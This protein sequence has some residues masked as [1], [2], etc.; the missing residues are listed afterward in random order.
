[1]IKKSLFILT[2][3]LWA[4]SLNANSFRDS[5]SAKIAPIADTYLLKTIGFAPSSQMAQEPS[6]WKTLV[7]LFSSEDE[8]AK[9]QAIANYIYNMYIIEAAAGFKNAPTIRLDTAYIGAL[10]PIYRSA[11]RNA[12]EIQDFYIDNLKEINNFLY[13]AFAQKMGLRYNPSDKENNRWQSLYI[14]ALVYTYNTTKSFA[15]LPGK[16]GLSS[17]ELSRIRMDQ[18]K[19]QIKANNYKNHNLSVL[20][21][22]IDP[23]Q[24]ID[25]YSRVGGKG[26]AKKYTYRPLSEEC[27]A[28]T[29]SFC[30]DICAATQNKYGTHKLFRV[31]EIYAY[32]E[33]NFLKNVQGKERFNKPGGGTYPEWYYHAAALLVFEDS[34]SLSFTVV[35]TLLSAEPISFEAWIN[36]FYKPTT[37]FTIKPFI[38]NKNTEKNI[39][40][41]KDI[42]S[43][44][45]PHQVRK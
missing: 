27:A 16:G 3:F 39:K 34:G 17:K 10:D 13:S 33:S 22:E 20:Y 7:S 36:M 14:Q 44:Y 30:K 41:N 1:M 38:R 19:R 6:I 42:P 8:E 40:N 9:Q 28:C 35:D 21:E 15:Y 25:M 37:H 45:Q 26:S 31:Y 24:A 11:F 23:M 5:L 29:Y 43:N 4:I 32:P 2:I 12:H 18:L